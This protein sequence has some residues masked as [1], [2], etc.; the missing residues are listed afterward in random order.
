MDKLIKARDYIEKIIYLKDDMPKPLRIIF[1]TTEYTS[2]TIACFT[3]FYGIFS[4]LKDIILFIKSGQHV[5]KDLYKVRLVSGQLLNISLTLI[6]GGLIIRMLHI[7]NLK[8][9]LL[10]L[11]VILIKELLIGKIDK[12]TSLVSQK[13]KENEII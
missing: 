7:T 10:I 12:E 2:Y 5:I 11:I 3:I 9:L 8:T 4:S 13:I 6:L 1:A